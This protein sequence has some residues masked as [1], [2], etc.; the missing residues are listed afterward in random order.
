MKLIPTSIMLP[1]FGKKSKEFYDS[2]EKIDAEKAF[3]IL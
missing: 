1:F 2:W 3:K